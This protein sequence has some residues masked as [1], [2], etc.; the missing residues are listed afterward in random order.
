MSP[1]RKE[2]EELL[3]RSISYIFPSREELSAYLLGG[4]KLKIYLGV[5]ATGPELHIGHAT[6]L[7][8]LEKLRRLGHEIIL[9]FGDFTARIGDPTDKGAARTRLSGEEVERNIKGWKAQART[10]LSFDDKK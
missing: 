7:I 2:I 1:D 3:T 9:L 6:N 8:F 5:D 10:I 4:K